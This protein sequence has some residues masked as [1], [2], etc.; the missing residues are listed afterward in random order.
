MRVAATSKKVTIS[1]LRCRNR[2]DESQGGVAN[3]DVLSFSTLAPAALSGRL[4]VLKEDAT[5]DCAPRPATGNR[6]I[7]ELVAGFL[8][9]CLWAETTERG[10]AFI[11]ISQFF[12]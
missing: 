2:N 3:R 5:L 9:R 4:V 8:D 12:R 10:S 1:E 11:S 7:L 6:V